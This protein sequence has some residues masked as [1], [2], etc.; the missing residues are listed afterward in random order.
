MNCRN[1]GAAMELFERRRYYFCNHCGTFHFIE[2]PAEDG[3]RVLE[4]PE[5]ATPCPLCAAPLAKSLLDDAYPVK[6]CEACRGLLLARTSFAEAVGRRRARQ[7]GPPAE[8]VP[9]DRRELKRVI[10]CPACRTQMDVHPYYGP[11]NVVIDTCSGCDLVWLDFGELQQIT[12][13]PGGDRGRSRMPAVTY[14]HAT[15]SADSRDDERGLRP[16]ESV[17]MLDAFD[18]LFGDY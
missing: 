17:T 10:T 4:R 5:P 15:G 3:V 12:D 1:C 13:A 18:A 7:T 11:G 6:H 16:G 8:P 14:G 9:L 2:T